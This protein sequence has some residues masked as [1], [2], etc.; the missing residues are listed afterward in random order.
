MPAGTTKQPKNDSIYM[1]KMM[2]QSNKIYLLYI[3]LNYKITK[4]N[5]RILKFIFYVN[6]HIKIFFNSLKIVTH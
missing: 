4:N 1:L 5:Y 2:K 3:V 6:K